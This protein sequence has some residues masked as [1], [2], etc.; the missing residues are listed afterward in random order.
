MQL[1][2]MLAYVGYT[3]EDLVAFFSRNQVLPRIS[4]LLALFITINTEP[5]CVWTHAH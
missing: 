4:N 5:G 3:P 2:N 1:L